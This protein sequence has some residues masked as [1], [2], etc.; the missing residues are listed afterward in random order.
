MTTL[1]DVEKRVIVLGEKVDR[2][3]KDISEIKVYMSS[4]MI[5]VYGGAGA[6]S[7]LISIVMFLLTK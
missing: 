7:I 6:M 3:E 2:I 5:K 4:M 1:T